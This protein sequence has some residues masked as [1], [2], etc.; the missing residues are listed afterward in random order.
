MLSAAPVE[1][2]ARFRRDGGHIIFAPTPADGYR[3]SEAARIRG[4]WLTAEEVEAFRR[5]YCLETKTVG[6]YVPD[7]RALI[8]PTSYGSDELD[9]E[10]LVLH[11]L[12]HA[13]TY[14]RVS[15]EA[16]A[17]EDLLRGLPRD[18]AAHVGQSAYC[19]REGEVGVRDQ[20]LEALAEA[21]VFD[22]VGRRADLSPALASA[23]DDILYGNDL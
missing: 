3:S 22:V 10:W 20:V 18:I 12:G 1:H 19:E 23:L 15:V 11:E 21:Y 13:L 8:F 9:L 5:R 16:G 4:R 2:L 6:V 14:H 17:H 7:L